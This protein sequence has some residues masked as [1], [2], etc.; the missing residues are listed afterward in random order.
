MNLQATSKRMILVICVSALIFILAGAV[1][2][3]SMAAL[4]F[5]LGV[6]LTSALNCVKAVMIERAVIKSAG[7]GG[8]AKNF[9]GL[10]YGLRLLLTLAVLAVC[11]VSPHI[12]VWGAAIGLLTLQI[13]AIS[14]KF[15]GTQDQTDSSVI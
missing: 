2:Y 13:S 8:N 4:P 10:Q 3:R 6:L 11:V 15:F 14:L 7:M 5:A 1:F 9:V 12:N